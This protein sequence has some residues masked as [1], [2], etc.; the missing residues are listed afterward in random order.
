[1]TIAGQYAH[2]CSQTKTHTQTQTQTQT[3]THTN[4]NTN[5]QTHTHKPLCGRENRPREVRNLAPHARSV[6]LLFG[7]CCGDPEVAGCVAVAVVAAAG[8]VRLLALWA[9][10]H[11]L[12]LYLHLIEF[13]LAQQSHYWHLLLLL[14][15][16]ILPA[17]SLLLDNVPLSEVNS[18]GFLGIGEIQQRWERMPS[19]QPHPTPPPSRADHINSTAT[20]SQVREPCRS[21]VFL[22]ILIWILTLA[23]STSC[24]VWGE[25]STVDMHRGGADS[26]GSAKF[27]VEELQRTYESTQPCKHRKR[28]NKRS[29]QRA[30]RRATEHGIT[31]YKG[32]WMTASQLG[33]PYVGHRDTPPNQKTCQLARD[34]DAN[35]SQ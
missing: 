16:C 9:L 22:V 3:H 30:Q 21:R 4:T 15:H 19:V 35:D 32:Q 29:Y 11:Y 1:M 33:M 8:A 24:T 14:H 18:L 17:A 6:V 31:W 2:T 27:H 10:L 23:T 12:V 25:G 5:T 26:E 7:G 13:V 28:T 34:T 20:R